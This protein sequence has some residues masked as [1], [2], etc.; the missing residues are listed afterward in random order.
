MD[1]LAAFLAARYDEAEARERRMLEMLAKAGPD[2]CIA[3]CF[4]DGTSSNAVDYNPWDVITDYDP[5]RRLADIKL[6]RAILA[7]HATETS[8]V[9]VRALPEDIAEGKPL[10][11][12]EDERQCV[13][14]GWFDGEHGG[15]E[16]VRQLGTEFDEHPGYQEGWKP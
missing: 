11:W 4:D 13:I 9:Q 1:D 3:V 6:K 10:W 7:E 14:C 5:K 15:C 8:R 12:Y 16:T 2:A